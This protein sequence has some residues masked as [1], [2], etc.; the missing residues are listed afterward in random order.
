MPNDPFV[1]VAALS[2][3][4][5]IRYLDA[6][7]QEAFDAGHALGAVRVPVED[8]IKQQRR[9]TSDLTTLPSGITPLGRSASILR[10]SL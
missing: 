8:G 2:T 7:D 1:D 4:G 6:R 9:P 5:P 3:L 10:P